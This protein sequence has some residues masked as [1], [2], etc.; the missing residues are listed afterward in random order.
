MVHWARVEWNLQ[1]SLRRK[2]LGH[3]VENKDDHMSLSQIVYCGERQLVLLPCWFCFDDE[4]RAACVRGVV[5]VFA[6]V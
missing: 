3:D 1:G 2:G 6:L 4:S 5:S